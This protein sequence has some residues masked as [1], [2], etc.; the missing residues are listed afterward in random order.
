MGAL[1]VCSMSGCRSERTAQGGGSHEAVLEDGK[2]S[3]TEISRQEIFREYEDYGLAY[4][5][6]KD[7]LTYDGKLVR[8]FED[9]YPVEAGQAGTDYFNEKGVTDIYAVRDNSEPVRRDDGS[10]DPR[11]RLLEIRE[12]P[13]EEFAGRDIEAIRHPKQQTA[14]A[15]EPMKPEEI[16]KMAEEYEPFG[17]TYAADE[18]VW[19]YNGERVRYFRDILTSNGENPEGGKFKGSVRIFGQEDGTVDI[20]TVRDYSTVNSDGNG[21]LISVEKYRIPS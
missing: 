4:N 19:Y 7:E 3:V 17:V 16:K 20:R 1:L 2:G 11:G 10:Y 18:D 12:F 14:L 6:G 13:A 21:T 5:S 9:Y 15:G 8:W